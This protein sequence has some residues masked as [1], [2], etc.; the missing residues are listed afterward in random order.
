MTFLHGDGRACAAVSAGEE[1][2]ACAPVSVSSPQNGSIVQLITPR[3]QGIL[4]AAHFIAH[5]CTNHTLLIPHYTHI[6]HFH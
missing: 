3:L 4:R 5:F 1:S 2:M 6:A